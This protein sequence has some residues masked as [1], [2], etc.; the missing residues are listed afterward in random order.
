[1]RTNSY[2][3]KYYNKSS[4]YLQKQS[5]RELVDN[6]L[7]RN[8]TKL[9]TYLKNLPEAVLEFKFNTPHSN[10]EYVPFALGLGS[11]CFL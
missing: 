7:F 5:D 6:I 3:L 2:I 1:M 4:S 8:I 9:V 11:S 10:F